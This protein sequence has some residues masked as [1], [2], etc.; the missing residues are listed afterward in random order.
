VE[1]EKKNVKPNSHLTRGD[2]KAGNPKK[3]KAGVKVRGLLKIT[4]GGKLFAKGDWK[5]ERRWWTLGGGP[6]S[7]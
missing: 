7:E 6:D 3:E 1:G 2:E 4:I 5:E